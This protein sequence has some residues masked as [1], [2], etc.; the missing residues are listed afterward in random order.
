MSYLCTHGIQGTDSSA[1]TGTSGQDTL[2]GQP[3][4]DSQQESRGDSSGRPHRGRVPHGRLQG[5]HRHARRQARKGLPGSRAPDRQARVR[6]M[7]PRQDHQVAGQ[8]FRNVPQRRH[9]QEILGPVL[10]R[11]PA[12]EGHLE[13][14][15]Y[16]NTRQNK[17]YPVET[18]PSPPRRFPR[19]QA[20]Q[21]QLPL[22]AQHRPLPPRGGRAAH[23]K[24]SPDTLPARRDRLRDQGRPQIRRPR[25]NPDGGICLQSHEISFIHPVRKTPMDI[26]VPAPSD[27]KGIR[28]G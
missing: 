16:R 6:N 28:Q 26:T 25:S 1:N 18:E 5:L 27:W 23:R 20:R 3:P 2:R 9:P 17:T 7:H 15:L 14:W 24:A 13:Q 19:R 4:P 8:A 12:A 21:T 11:T 10:R 22:P